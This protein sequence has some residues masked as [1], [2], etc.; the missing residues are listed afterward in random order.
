MQRLMQTFVS[1]LVAALPLA[2]TIAVTV[3]LVN[4]VAGYVGPS[5]P[6]GEFLSRLGLGVTSSSV[7]AYMAGLVTVVVAV[8]LLGLIVETR[9]GDWLSALVDRLMKR[10]PIVSSVYGLSKQFTAIVDLKG[11]DNVKSMSSVWCF[12]GG[13]PGAAVLALL[14]SSK[15]VLIGGREYLGILVPSAPVPVGGA[16]VYVPSSWVKPA[17]GGI[18]HLMNV[19]VSMGGTP[20]RN[21]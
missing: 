8:Y 3:W 2:L 9:I 16:L 11:T 10:V 15:P 20:P 12:F 6:V 1:G 7:A 17:E 14:A 21:S 13:E 18:E 5:S 4:L 19:Y